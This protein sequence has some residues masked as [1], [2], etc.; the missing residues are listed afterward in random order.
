MGGEG[1]LGCPGRFV[2]NGSVGPG[3]VIVGFAGSFSSEYNLVCF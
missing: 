3:R 1:C 2:S